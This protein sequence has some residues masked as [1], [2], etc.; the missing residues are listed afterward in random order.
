MSSFSH[1]VCR[2]LPPHLHARSMCQG[3]TIILGMCALFGAA[4]AIAVLITHLAPTV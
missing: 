3:S 4:T 1:Y 2:H